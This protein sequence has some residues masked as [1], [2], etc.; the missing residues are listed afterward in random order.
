ME[1]RTMSLKDIH[2]Y[3]NNPRKNDEAVAYV[4][5]SIKQCTYVA[6][7]IVDEDG[8]ILAGHTRWKALKKLGKKEAEV[9]IKAGLS[10]EQKRKYRILDNKTNEFAEW[11]DDL[12]RQEL[13]GLDFEGFDFE[14]LAE[15]K[16]KEDNQYSMKVNI[17][18]YEVT[19]IKPT[20]G[21]MVNTDK[22][23][24]MIMEIEAADI[25]AE[26]KAFL[27]S[28]AHRHN[29]FNYR[30]IAEYYA[31]C[32]SPQ[33]QELMERSALVIIDV[34]DAIKNGYAE[35]IDSLV[36]LKDGEGIDED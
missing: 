30:N 11:D 23:D 35:L 31:N 22:A 2:P 29:V 27:I 9:I 21:D 7:I 33:M 12:L 34:D 36:D 4:M 15:E 32:A 25:S 5:E 14:L 16:K 3:E 8:I 1:L 13:E 24:A 10:E 18:H 20:F 26:E 28:A 19:G 17:P 6:P